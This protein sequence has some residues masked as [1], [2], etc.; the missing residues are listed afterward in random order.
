NP[1]LVSNFVPSTHGSGVASNGT[2]VRASGS[3]VLSIE[4]AMYSLGPGVAA[5]VLST[6]RSAAVGFGSGVNA[7]RISRTTNT[8]L[9]QRGAWYVRSQADK[10]TPLRDDLTDAHILSGGDRGVSLDRH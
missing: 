10:L 4:H 1:A 6:L 3:H 5:A 9:S 2:H 7:K 8:T